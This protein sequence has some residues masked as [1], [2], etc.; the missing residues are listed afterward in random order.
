[1]TSLPDEPPKKK[2]KPK[3][4]IPKLVS[5]RIKPGDSYWDSW[6]KLSWSEGQNVKSKIDPEMLRKLGYQTKF[7]YPCLL[8]QI[9]RDVKN[10]ANLG[11]KEE[12]QVT[13]KATNAPS[14]FEDGEKVS[15]EL[16]SW[17]AKGFVVGPFEDNEVPFKKV[18]I[19]G[20]MTKVK[21]NGAVRPIL[22]FS[23]GDPKSVNEGMNKKDFPAVMSS[24][25]NWVRIL[26]RCGS[27]ARFCKNDW[28]NAYKNI[29]INKSDIW[30]Q[31]FKWLE[32]TFF[33]LCLVFGGVSSAGL[34]D[35]LAKLILWI[36]LVHAHFPEHLVAQHLDDVCGASPKG[37]DSVDR[38][39]KAYRDVCDAIGVDLADPSDPDKAFPPTTNGI[40]LGIC[41]DTEEGINGTWYL[42]EDKMAD[43][44][45]MLEKA[46]EGEE[47][48]QRFIKSLCGKLI[49]LRCLVEDSKFRMSQ[50]IQAANQTEVM[51]ARVEISDWCRS[52]MFWWKTSLPVFS[53]RSALMDPDRRAGPFAPVKSFGRG[54]SMKI[55]PKTWT[56]L[57]WGDKINKGFKTVNGR[58]T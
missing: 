41:Y 36:A 6:P 48:S 21:P 55:Y 24:T 23:R 27:G 40:V 54:V 25:Q 29:R 10:G 45:I 2:F 44:I 57:Q 38:F 8:E 13:S 49:H 15:D 4:D 46:M 32:K 3:Q 1:M 50:I 31:G 12:C 26:L 18:K 47:S 5:Y 58:H 16:A 35:R 28:A 53:N 52:D 37:T 11:V 51:T 14:A 20:L 30:M 33:E 9:Y 39:Y 34:F 43:I 7:P 42:R 19:S 22:N 17:I 56:V